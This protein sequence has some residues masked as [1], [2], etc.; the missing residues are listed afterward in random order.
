MLTLCCVPHMACVFTCFCAVAGLRP[1]N[2]TANKQE[3]LEFC[4]DKGIEPMVQV[5]K[6]SEVRSRGGSDCQLLCKSSGSYCAAAGSCSPHSRRI[7]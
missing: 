3:M 5:M 2:T 1:V 7:C 6:L 4:A